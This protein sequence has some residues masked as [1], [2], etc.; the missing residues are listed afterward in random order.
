MTGIG[1]NFAGTGRQRLRRRLAAVTRSSDGFAITPVE[2]A[3][4][5]EWAELAGLAAT[6]NVFFAPEF[7]LPLVRHLGGSVG[8]A[9]VRS[10]DQLIAAAPVTQSRLGR[11]APAIRLFANAYAPLGAPLV[12]RS[13]IVAGAAGLVDGAARRGVNLVLPDMT[14]DGPLAAAFAAAARQS[15]RPIAVIGAHRRGVLERAGEGSM[16]PRQALSQRR[17]R[18]YRRQMLR[19]A[20]H[21]AVKI[22]AARDLAGVV[23]EF[24]VFL[25]LEAA[26]WKGRRGS[27]L[28]SDPQTVAFARAAVADLAAAGR[29]RIDAIRLVDRPVAMLVTLLAGHTAYSWKIAYDEEFARFSPGAQLMLEVGR[30]VFADDAGVTRIDSCAVA[31]HPMVDHVWKD[32]IAI[33]TMIIGPQGGGV[34][35]KA[36]VATAE[37]ELAARALARRLKQHYG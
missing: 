32:R 14:L 25:R 2:S 6:D 15:G 27:A 19:L 20:D 28:L 17:R 18:E 10:G 34:V 3:A 5:G 9:T 30:A 7:V 36:G 24:E 37:A 12:D 26:G 23:A 22:G 33:G 11:I 21:G 8:L 31:D 4:V 13:M 1:L 35:H 16:D 29:A